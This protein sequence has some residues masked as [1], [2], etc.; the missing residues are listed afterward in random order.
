VDLD[1]GWAGEYLRGYLLKEGYM[2][3]PLTELSP[4]ITASLGV[5]YGCN[6]R[7]SYCSIW[8]F[9]LAHTHIDDLAMAVDELVDCGVM[10]ISLTGGEPLMHPHIADVVNRIH[11]HGVRSSLITN[12]LLLRTSRLISVLE[13]G[14]N[15]L[16]VSL[17]TLDPATYTRIRGVA[18]EPVL[19]GIESLLRQHARF[20]QL[21]ISVN[22]VISRV[23][24]GE[25]IPLIETCTSLGV[26]VGFQP[27]HAPFADAAM[28]VDDLQFSEANY[29]E[30]V[31]L[32]E[33]LIQMKH[34]GYPILNSAAYL[35]GIPD[36]L[37]YQRLPPE[38]SC[39]AGF[40]TIVVDHELN[41]RSCWA[42]KRLGNLRK[43][44]LLQLWR[45]EKYFERR[46]RMLKLDCP[47]CWLRCHTEH[48]SEDIIA[49]WLGAV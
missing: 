33:H 22:C 9:P 37:V 35:R 10:L 4:P 29:A 46:N 13:A 32:G 20:P 41:I 12:G 48:R 19:K 25:I 44:R 24:I 5:N 1:L 7:C 36:Y 23:N 14:L 45:S 11:A 21:T 8:H 38:F 6:S 34:D 43:D 17:D 47:G 42:M 15:S 2:S 49:E 30:L 26:K 3:A 16:V 31:A 27:L 28:P 18:L 40:T 39:N